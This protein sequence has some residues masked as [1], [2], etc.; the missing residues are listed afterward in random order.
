M[1]SRPGRNP[2]TSERADPGRVADARLHDRRK[3]M[4]LAGYQDVQSPHPN[5]MPEKGE[6]TRRASR[7][8]DGE[9]PGSA[10]TAWRRL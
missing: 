4:R 1:R 9:G 8:L 6:H 10:M 3:G 7:D 5:R 2:A